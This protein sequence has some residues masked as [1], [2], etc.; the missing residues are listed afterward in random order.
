MFFIIYV[1]MLLLL[2]VFVLGGKLGGHFSSLEA[3]KVSE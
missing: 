1:P 3:T 2:K